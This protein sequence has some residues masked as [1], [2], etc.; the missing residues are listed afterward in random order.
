V[1]ERGKEHQKRRKINLK[2]RREKCQN[3]RKER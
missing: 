2:N 3:Q 1:F